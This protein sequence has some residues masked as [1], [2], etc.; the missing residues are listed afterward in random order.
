MKDNYESIIANA[1]QT[2]KALPQAFGVP[3]RISERVVR[4]LETEGD[5]GIFDAKRPSCDEVVD[6]LSHS[7]YVQPGESPRDMVFVH[8]LGMLANALLNMMCDYY[9]CEGRIRHV[10]QIDEEAGRARALAGLN[11]WLRAT[12]RGTVTLPDAIEYVR[13][14]RDLHALCRETIG[15]NPHLGESLWS[16]LVTWKG[17]YSTDL[18]TK[19]GNYWILVHIGHLRRFRKVFRSEFLAACVWNKTADWAVPWKGLYDELD[20]DD[21]LAIPEAIEAAL[22]HGVSP[23]RLLTSECDAEVIENTDWY[24]KLK[25]DNA[26][27]PHASHPCALYIED[28]GGSSGLLNDDDEAALNQSLLGVFLGA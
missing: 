14:E 13:T 15:G 10:R 20:E 1:I 2:A 7:W 28:E 3:D 18:Q 8:F 16:S 26:M 19:L 4:L 12:R 22:R 25:W 24:W 17:N 11:R 21:R 5:F 23:I 27:D 6:A 9:S